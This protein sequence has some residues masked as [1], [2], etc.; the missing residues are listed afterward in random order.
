MTAKSP[1]GQQCNRYL[2]LGWLVRHPLLRCQLPP[3]LF[4]WQ[5]WRIYSQA[6]NYVSQNDFSYMVMGYSWSKEEL[7]HDLEGENKAAVISLCRCFLARHHTEVHCGFQLVLP[8]PSS[9]FSSF[10]SC[11]SC[12]LENSN[13]P[14]AIWQQTH[15]IRSHTEE[16][17]FH[18]SLLAHSL[19]CLTPMLCFLDGQDGD[20]S[21][22]L[23][24]SDRH[25][26]R[27]CHSYVM[28]NSFNEI[29]VPSH[30]S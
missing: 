11:W 13:P 1:I 24:L 8:L 17:A 21:L 12:C 22:I 7:A 18:G 10:P 14:P 27:S 28:S 9:N 26:L 30:S 2:A 20:L 5:L 6:G 15:R 3:A 23:Q 4:K 19:H 25:F 16:P 29:P